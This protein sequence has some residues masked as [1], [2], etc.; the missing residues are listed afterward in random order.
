VIVGRCDLG[1]FGLALMWGG[2]KCIRVGW[3]INE[4]LAER[5]VGVYDTQQ[6]KGTALPILIGAVL[7]LLGAPLA[8]AAVVPIGVFEK[9]MGRTRNTTLWDNNQSADSL[10][11]WGDMF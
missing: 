8:V 11:R 3:E 9:L 5:W 2:Y 6:A 1:V 10:G 4:D 7:V